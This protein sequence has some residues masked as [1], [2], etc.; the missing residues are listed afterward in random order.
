M[1][2]LQICE[3]IDAPKAINR[4]RIVELY[5]SLDGKRSRLS[6]QTFPTLEQAREWVARQRDV[7]E[8][9]R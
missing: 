7:N 1:R 8:E 5:D 3:W 2:A 6:S 4:F 9:S